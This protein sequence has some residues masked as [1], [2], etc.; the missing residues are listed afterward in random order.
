[1]PKRGG[2][3]GKNLTP[4]YLE[5]PIQLSMRFSIIVFLWV[6]KTGKRISRDM[7]RLTPLF[8][9]DSFLSQGIFSCRKFYDEGSIELFLDANVSHA[10]AAY[11]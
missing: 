6:Y 4:A 9:Y 5:N 8:L 7:P 2:G 3:G 10:W 11:Q 1:M